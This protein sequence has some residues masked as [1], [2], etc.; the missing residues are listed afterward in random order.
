M[1][2]MVG[3]RGLRVF[4]LALLAAAALGLTA[5]GLLGESAGVSNL[6]AGDLA[7]GLW[8]VFVGA[9]ALYVGLY[10]I[11]VK[12]F[13]GTLSSTESVSNPFAR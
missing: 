3:D 2:T 7:V 1:E 12:E 10:L 8:E 4:R 6:L 9:L 5:I 11:G 13:L